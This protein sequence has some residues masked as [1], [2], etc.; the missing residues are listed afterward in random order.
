MNI[1]AIAT[2]AVMRVLGDTGLYLPC[3]GQVS[4]VRV[5]LRRPERIISGFEGT[6]L[7]NDGRII[8]IERAQLTVDPQPNDKIKVD[9]IIYMVRSAKPTSSNIVWELDCVPA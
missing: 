3:V 5:F 6:K 8:E 4:M 2:G 7:N 1:A 9:N